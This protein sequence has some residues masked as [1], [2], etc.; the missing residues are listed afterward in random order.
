L[1]AARRFGPSTAMALSPYLMK[2]HGDILESP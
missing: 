1:N 2:I